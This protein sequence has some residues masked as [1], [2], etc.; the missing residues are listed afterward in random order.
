M[1][2]I[3][4]SLDC[5]DEKVKNKIIFFTLSILILVQGAMCI[6]KNYYLNNCF[7]QNKYFEIYVPLSWK[8]KWKVLKGSNERNNSNAVANYYAIYNKCNIAEIYVL[9]VK[10]EYDRFGYGNFALPNGGSFI[11]ETKDNKYIFIWSDYGYGFFQSGGK[12]FLK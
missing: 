5:L 9:E 8:G 4:S 12:I 7:Y 1:K 10:N 3:F 2:K 6:Y 11:G